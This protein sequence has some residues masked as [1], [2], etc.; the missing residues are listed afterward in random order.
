VRNE[1]EAIAALNATILAEYGP[2]G[3][4]RAAT[5]LRVVFME[6]YRTYEEQIVVAH[7]AQVMVS[8]HGGGVANC[9][10]MRPGSVMLEFTSPAG[11]TLPNMYHSMCKRAGIHHRGVVASEDPSDAAENNPQWRS[12]PR[13]FSN[14]VI[15]PSLM[16]AEARVALATYKKAYLT[17]R[18][19][20]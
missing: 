17:Q 16:A 5:A 6:D 3:V 1:A 7:S 20:R 2:M 19:N 13:L 9:I 11:K 10:W 18:H 15:P 8:P 12:N 14:L 4:E